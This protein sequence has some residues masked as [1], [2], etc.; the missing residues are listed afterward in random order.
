MMM[1]MVMFSTVILHVQTRSWSIEPTAAIVGSRCRAW[2]G[3]RCG[4]WMLELWFSRW[5]CNCSQRSQE[6][7]QSFLQSRQQ[8]HVSS[9]ASQRFADRKFRC[10]RSSI[11]CS[12]NFAWFWGWQRCLNQPSYWKACCA[13]IVPFWCQTLCFCL[14]EWCGKQIFF[15]LYC[16][17]LSG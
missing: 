1:M 17:R 14:W 15:T 16:S 7:N 9:F 10:N 4:R 8:K 12:A 6:E 13:I 11:W 5:C 2:T 3:H